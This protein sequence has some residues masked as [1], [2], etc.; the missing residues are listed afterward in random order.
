MTKTFKLTRYFSVVSLALIV[1][2]SVVLSYAYH[3]HAEQELILRGDQRNQAQA[4]LLVNLLNL[5]SGLH[6]AATPERGKATAENDENE[7]YMQRVLQRMMAGTTLRKFKFYNPS[8][9]VVYSSEAA[10]AGGNQVTNPGFKTAAAGGRQVELTRR[11]MSSIFDGGV[12]STDVLGSYLPIHDDAHQLV[13]VVEVVD[14][15][16][17]LVAAINETR[18]KVLALTAG[19]MLLLYALLMVIIVRADRIISGNAAQLQAESTERARALVQ[20]EHVRELAQRASSEAQAQRVQAEVARAESEAARGEA[21][22][23][24]RAK[25]Q[26]LAN[27]SHEIRT[28]MNSIIGF[29]DLVLLEPLPNPL[30]EYVG[31]IKASAVSLLGIIN[32]VLDLSKLDAGKVALQMERFSPRELASSVMAAVAPLAADKNLQLREVFDRDLP[33]WLKGDSRRLQQALM[34]LMDNAVKFTTEG[35]VTLSIEHISTGP[36]A[37]L[38]FKVSDTGI[39]IAPNDMERIFKP[40][41]QVTA[42]SAPAYGGTGLGLALA[43]GLVQLMNGK[44]AASS[45][46][47]HGSEF[48]FSAT[49]VPVFVSDQL[50]ASAPVPLEATLDA[51]QMQS[52]TVLLVEDNPINQ[53]LAQNMLKRLGCSVI[54]AVDGLQGAKL[55][56]QPGIDLILMDMQMPVMDGL[57]STRTIRA[58]EAQTGRLPVPIVAL[59]ANAMESDKR[60]CI[61]AGMNGFM[62]KPYQFADLERMVRRYLRA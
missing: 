12:Q 13:G 9:L 3:R 58:E 43:S 45:S 32:D 36:E 62:S 50:V 29:S 35:V 26:F 24:N 47:G 28:P 11:G 38:A 57:Q 25:S 22:F 51:Q 16:S 42:D 8:G 60:A 6:L 2:V 17:Q 41:E 53:K 49:F 54:L 48:S 55:A 44:L 5:Q 19:L 61:G 10:Q 52:K 15:V 34:I 18:Y 1:L 4:R 33:A 40:F 21:D 30:P 14:D 7:Q 46:L 59:T 56:R 23:A 39:G 27:M 31:H 37:V 20:A